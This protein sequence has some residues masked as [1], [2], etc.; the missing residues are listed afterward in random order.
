MGVTAGLVYQIEELK[1]KRNAIV[2]VHNYQPGDVQDI[3]DF[4]GDSLDLSRKAAQTRAKVIV[5]CGVYFMAE[6]AAILSPEKTV[7]IPDASAGCP[8]ADMIDAARLREMK[9][10]HPGAAVVAYVNSTAE[11]KA[12]S[13]ICCTSANAVQI[14]ESLG[15][16]EIIFVPDKYLGGYVA[17]K[18]GKNLILWEGYCPVHVKI[19]AEDI[20]QARKDHPKAEVLAHPECTP[21]VSDI[22]DRVLST[23]G[24][25]NYVEHADHKE[26]IIAT[27]VDIIYRLKK[28]NPDKIFYPATDRATCPNM[29]KTIPEKVLWSLDQMKHVVKVDI[30]I[31]E[32]ARQAIEKML[33]FSRAD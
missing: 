7:L 29:K 5:F 4:L 31:R 23:S 14:V 22:A 1:K 12:E 20:L 24:M 32:K 17:K 21:A 11:V 18:T 2:L 6:T 19:L 8:M 9:K 33:G 28:D 16:R 26:F 3:A 30:R 27:E 15:D 10:L 25:C 13:D